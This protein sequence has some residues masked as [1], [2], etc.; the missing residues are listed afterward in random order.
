MSM[1]ELAVAGTV[2]GVVS[3]VLLIIVVIVGPKPLIEYIRLTWIYMWWQD[4]FGT[5]RYKWLRCEISK[6]GMT[7]TNDIDLS[8][9][10]RKV[11][12]SWD[13]NSAQLDELLNAIKI[14]N[15]TKVFPLDLI[16][17]CAQSITS[18]NKH[19]TAWKIVHTMIQKVDDADDNISLDIKSRNEACQD[20]VAK[21]KSIVARLESISFRFQ[22][23]I[24]K[25][26][27]KNTFTIEN[28]VHEII[29]TIKSQVSKKI[30]ENDA[31]WL[32]F[33]CAF[34]FYDY[35]KSVQEKT[36]NVPSREQMTLTPLSE[37]IELISELLPGYR[38]SL[39]NQK[40]EK[41]LISKT[42]QSLININDDEIVINLDYSLV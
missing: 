31:N 40:L 19:L 12:Y 32:M 9:V 26:D 20:I 23:N 18:D 14:Y 21:L 37:Q 41:I 39:T 7:K 22:M 36:A 15:K 17:H 29:K 11:L 38:V 1:N 8:Y 30:E 16:C 42:T 27:Y 34:E 6:K 24:K 33:S 5:W 28:A 4:I 10:C 3:T 25:K 13:P 2:L 35:L